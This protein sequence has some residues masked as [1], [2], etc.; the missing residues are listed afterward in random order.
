LEKRVES[1]HLE[2]QGTRNKGKEKTRMNGKRE[3]ET[4]KREEVVERTASVGVGNPALELLSNAVLPG[5]TA[6]CAEALPRLLR[7]T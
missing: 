1:P 2:K 4:E 6:F 7:N 3:R 5:L